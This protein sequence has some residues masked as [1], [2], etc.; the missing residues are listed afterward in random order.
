MMSTMADDSQRPSMDGIRSNRNGVAAP[1]A[2]RAKA[3]KQTPAPAATP[4]QEQAPNDQVAAAPKPRR[5]RL[6]RF[7]VFVFSLA[8]IAGLL[9][10]AYWLYLNF[11]I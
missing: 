9:F 1:A 8:I 3:A 6:R 11:Y 2:P 7:I 4:A 5:R 10:G